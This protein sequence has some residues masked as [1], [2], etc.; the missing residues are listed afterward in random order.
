MG[1]NRYP[2][3]TYAYSAISVKIQQD[4]RRNQ[5]PPKTETATRSTT[6][7]PKSLDPTGLSFL[8]ITTKPKRRA[9]TPL[10]LSLSLYI[11]YIQNSYPSLSLK[12]S[13]SLSV[14]FKKKKWLGLSIRWRKGPRSS[15]SSSRKVWRLWEIHARKAGIKSSISDADI[16]STT[17]YSCMASFPWYRYCYCHT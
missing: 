16:I 6:R 17:S 9:L 10:S 12:N 15:R 11:I 14:Y 4:P 2:T 3:S 5:K 7:V 8:K 1:P 13:L